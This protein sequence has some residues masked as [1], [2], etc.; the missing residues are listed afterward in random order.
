MLR[1]S[2]D[3]NSKCKMQPI[4]IQGILYPKKENV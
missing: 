1:I 3:R 2:E 4:Y